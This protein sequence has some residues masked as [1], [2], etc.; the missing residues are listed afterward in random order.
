MNDN[1]P[2]ATRFFYTV[3]AAT[4]FAYGVVIVDAY[5][6]LSLANDHEGVRSQA[7]Q[8]SSPAHSEDAANQPWQQK[9]HPFLAGALALIVIRLAY[10]GWHIGGR[11]FI[12]PVAVLVLLSSLVLRDLPVPTLRAQLWTQ[13]LQI[14]GAIAI[15]ALLWWLALREQ[16]FWRSTV[17]DS[18]QLRA[19]RLRVLVAT[20]LAVAATILGSWSSVNAI[21]LP[22]VEFPACQGFWW[23]PM[24]LIDAF[25]LSRLSDA[26]GIGASLTEPAATA[27]HM[28]H[29][30]VSLITLLY[31]GWLALCVF[32]TGAGHNLCRYG[33]MVL[34]L[35]TCEV[36]LGI[37]TVVTGM[38]MVTL[39]AHATVAALLLLSMITLY[40]ATLPRYR[41]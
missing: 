8:P 2:L 22:C 18:R 16:R 17:V 4:L 11:R 39:L 28:T 10:L 6:R 29:R 9:V 41:K 21:G 33:L 26:A 35:L 27:M 25:S 20:A 19:L 24:D 40:H 15:L 7:V 1:S 12:V 31:A 38:P 32:W 14:V 34:A 5:S 36:S 3:L 23:P 13:L 30:L 37:M